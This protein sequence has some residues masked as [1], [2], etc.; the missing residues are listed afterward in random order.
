MFVGAMGFEPT[1]AITSYEYTRYQ[2]ASIYPSVW[3]SRTSI[4]FFGYTSKFYV[5]YICEKIDLFCNEHFHPN[6]VGIQI[7]TK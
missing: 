2:R 3:K 5:L 4:V 6:K 7:L 1:F